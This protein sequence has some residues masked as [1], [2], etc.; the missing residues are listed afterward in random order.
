[1]TT[2]L[3]FPALRCCMLL[4]LFLFV[5]GAA[6]A[7]SA[8]G[9]IEGRVLNAENG[10]YLT[11]ARVTIDGTNVQVFTDQSGRFRLT[12]VPAG[13][14]RVVAFYTGLTPQTL[15]VAVQAGQTAQLDINLTSDQEAPR[16]PDEVL[17]LDVLVVAAKR[18]RDSAAMA[19]NE[20][21]FAPNIK[22]VTST[23]AFGDIPEG[24]IGDFAKFLPGVTVDYVATDARTI[25]LRGVAPNYTAITVDGV[26]LASANSSNPG[27]QFELEQVSLNNTARIEIFK[28][29]TPD[30]S[31][32]ALGGGG[33]LVPRSALEQEKASFKYRAFAALN[34]TAEKTLSKSHGPSNVPSVK[35]KPGFDFVYVK[36]VNENFGYTLSVLESN[37][38]NP[39]DMTFT[40]W[41]PYQG[42]RI[43][44]TPEHPYLANYFARPNPKTN[45]RESIGVTADWRFAPNDVLSVSAQWNYYNAAFYT[46]NA[47]YDV[48]NALPTNADPV[49]G[50]VPQEAV[51]GAVGAGSVVLGNAAIRHKYG[52]TYSADMKWRHTGRIWKR[53][54]ALSLSHAANHS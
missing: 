25:S 39:Q 19:I 34:G 49:T 11:N 20:Q 32:D 23:D 21:R 9:S 44:A 12:D 30:I 43:G 14:V 33:N 51:H 2:L 4:G 40:S 50:W 27:R 29:R 47:T 35:I 15:P 46:R 26:R 37:T 53:A 5:G 13:R 45:Q 16:K 6:L 41:A 24:N 28:S 10:R 1:M 42:N 48:G 18:D 36:P 52:T 54:A 17:T 7:Q 22:R 38:Y 31:A 3:K 8:V